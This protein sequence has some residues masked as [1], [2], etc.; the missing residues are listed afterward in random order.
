MQRAAFL[1]NQYI[2]DHE[3]KQIKEGRKATLASYGIETANGIEREAVLAIPGFGP[4]LTQNLLDWRAEMERGFR[5]DAKTGIPQEHVKALN[6]KYWQVQQVLQMTLQQGPAKLRAITA[7]A[8][9]HL[10]QIYAQIQGSL[11]KMAQAEADLSVL[12]RTALGR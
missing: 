4:S 7:Q 8:N 11:I 5:F 1:D 3:I 2:S 12:D 6:V 9:Q 10:G